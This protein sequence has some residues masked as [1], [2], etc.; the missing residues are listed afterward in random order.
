MKIPNTNQCQELLK[1]YKTPERIIN[2]ILTVNKLALFLA[3]KIKQSGIT[4]NIE[5]VNASSLLHDIDKLMTLD[6]PES[7]GEIAEQILTKEGYPEIGKSINT[8]GIINIK[9][10]KTW[11]DKVLVY[12]DFR[13]QDNNIVSLSERF[14]YGRKRY[15]GTV[16]EE[17]V[18]LA[19]ELEK[20]ICNKININP[21]ILKIFNHKDTS[22]Q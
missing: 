17:K 11:E 4:I 3:K 18:Q 13:A 8:H 14:E 5:F 16:T 1:K 20:Q 22:I 2:H 9:K 15:P 10:I 12:A 21:Q 19:Y 6:K 7:H